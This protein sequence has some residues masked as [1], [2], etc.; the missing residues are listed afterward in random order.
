MG[1]CIQRV[2]S[3]THMAYEAELALLVPIIDK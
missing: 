3:A 1:V 2:M